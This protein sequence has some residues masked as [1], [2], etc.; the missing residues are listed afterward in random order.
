MLVAKTHVLALRCEAVAN[1]FLSDD[2]KKKVVT[3]VQDVEAKSSAEIVVSV[4]GRCDDYR[5]VDLRAGL[6]AA[7][8]TIFALIYH[9]AEID[10]NLMPLETLVAFV[11]VSLLVSRVGSLKRLLLPAARTRARALE[12]A[13]AHFVEAGIS[14][15]RDRSGI[16]IFVSLLEKHVTVVADTGIDEKRLGAAWTAKVAELDRA[17]AAMNVDAFA[18]ALTGIGPILGAAYPR[19]EDDVN[20]LPDAP[21]FATTGGAA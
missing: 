16:L 6:I 9:P 8:L 3:A 18:A 4:R 10:E 7:I 20:E 1:P 11:I 5:D 17:C 12:A 13:R 14:R 15:T 21:L 2:A 19:R